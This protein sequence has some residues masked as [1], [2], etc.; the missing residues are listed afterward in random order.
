MPD[1]VLLVGH[2]SRSGAGQAE[3]AELAASVSAALAGVEVRL[4]YLELCDPPA[5]A[6]IDEMLAAGA[7]H[8]VVVPVM[9]HAAGHSKSDVPAIV[10]E[11]RRRRPAARIDYARPFGV[12]HALLALARR[13][14]AAAGGLG[15]P[16]AVLSRGTSDPDANAEAYRAARLVAEMVGAP[17]VV[18]GFCGVTW[19]DVPTALEQLRRLGAGRVVGFAWF[20]ARG[21]LLDRIGEDYA[22]FGAATGMEVIDAGYLGTGPELTGLVLARV[23]EAARGA[24]ASHCDA[25]AYRR[26][27][28][29]LED[30][31]GM[32]IGAGHSHLAAAHRHGPLPSGHDQ[33]SPLP[34]G[35][36][37]PGPLPSGHDHPGRQ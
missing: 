9:L 27:F 1:S 2:G 13:R 18:P 26:P 35:H 11:A 28:P 36:D 4:G 14:I 32:A 23:D 21:V 34:S 3:M 24:A 16:L 6:V 20:L 15:A 25:C 29:G 33:P 8:L 10:A 22:R 17:L 7:R 5:S 30:R 37:Q 19:P 31:V 12:D